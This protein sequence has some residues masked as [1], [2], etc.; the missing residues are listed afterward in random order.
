MNDL[1]TIVNAPLRGDRKKNPDTIALRLV[2]L[3]E[4]PILLGGEYR[5]RSEYWTLDRNGNAARIR[6]NGRLKTWKKDPTRY[7]QGFKWGMYEAFRWTTQE[8]LD[9]LYV[10]A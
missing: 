7:E 4:L 6:C 1:H 3:E 10:E 5:Q 2:T 9:N 8:M